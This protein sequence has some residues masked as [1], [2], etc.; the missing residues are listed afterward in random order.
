MMNQRLLWVLAMSLGLVSRTAKAEEVPADEPVTDDAAVAG[1]NE[2]E[3]PEAI[4]KEPTAEAD[5]SAEARLVADAE[6]GGSPVELPGRT[7]YFVGARYRLIVVPKFIIGMFADGGKSVSVHS[8]GAEFAIR[9]DGF[10]YNLGAWLAAYSMSPVE[11]KA[12]SD[13]EDAWELVESKIKVLYF[14]ADFLWSYELTPELALNYGMGAGLGLVFGPLYRNQAYRAPDGSFQPCIGQGNPQTA[15]Q[16]CGADND[17]YNDYE[18]P[19][20]ANGGSKPVVF[21]WLAL[22]TGLRYK[23]HRNFVA[24][25]DAG[26]G[27]SGFFIG[28]GGDYGL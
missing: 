19:S 15:V 6:L 7:Y 13:G 26:F 21:P 9:K 4:Q 1:V 2:E 28:L 25:L 24:R 22:Q 23:P 10:E 16:Y 3:P 18:E 8:G 20:W 5:D 12:T 17:H 27:L 14:T 11:F